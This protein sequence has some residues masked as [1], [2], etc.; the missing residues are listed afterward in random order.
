MSFPIYKDH[1]IEDKI[2]LNKAWFDNRPIFWSS[3]DGGLFKIHSIILI[4][5][6]NNPEYMTISQLY[7]LFGEELIYKSLKGFENRFEEKTLKRVHA[8][9]ELCKEVDNAK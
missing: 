1:N 2:P 7:Y 6:N 4:A 8:T 5:I 3:K 9:I